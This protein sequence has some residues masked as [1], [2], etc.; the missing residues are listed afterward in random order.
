MSRAGQVRDSV[1]ARNLSL[2]GHFSQDV[3]QRD[4]LERADVITLA[5]DL[6]EL[7][8]LIKGP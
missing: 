8:T 6:V 1:L 5:D 2:A 3:P 7:A 4:R